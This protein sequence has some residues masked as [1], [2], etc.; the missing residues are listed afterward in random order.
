M[1]IKVLCPI[2]QAD[3]QA[4]DAQGCHGDSDGVLMV[5]MVRVVMM[6][7]VMMMVVMMLMVVTVRVVML[8]PYD[9]LLFNSLFLCLHFSQLFVLLPVHKMLA[10]IFQMR[11]YAHL[12]LPQ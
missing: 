8:L 12:S 6:V 7:M 2:G 9:F 11:M 5:V 1:D 4:H 3:A 10:C